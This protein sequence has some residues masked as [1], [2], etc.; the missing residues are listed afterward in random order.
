MT[1]LFATDAALASM[2]ANRN[3]DRF[4][5]G[6]KRFYPNGSPIRRLRL[7][8]EQS[9]RFYYAAP[10][11]LTAALPPATPVPPSG[12]FLANCRVAVT[13]LDNLSA[14][15]RGD[16]VPIRIAGKVMS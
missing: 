6:L 14:L 1:T 12:A 13:R 5:D 7:I 9:G 2:T 15:D 4:S 10:E 3:T 16:N 11:E 8:G